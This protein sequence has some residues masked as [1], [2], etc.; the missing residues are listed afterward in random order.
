MRK[1]VCYY[2]LCWL[3]RIFLPDKGWL[4]MVIYRQKNTGRLICE[5][6][7]TGALSALVCF[8]QGAPS[9]QTTGNSPAQNPSEGQSASPN[10]PNK[11]VLTVG[12]TKVTQEDMDY[13]INN[14][15]P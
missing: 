8:G 1:C 4:G 11:V 10:S 5:L 3:K 15:N 12:N 9:A 13:L 14:L 2:Q 7:L 6:F